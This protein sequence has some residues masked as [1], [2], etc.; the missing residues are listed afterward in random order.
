[1]ANYRIL[2]TVE[3]VGFS[4]LSG[5][6]KKEGKKKKLLHFLCSTMTEHPEIEEHQKGS[7]FTPTL[8][9]CII[10]LSCDRDKELGI[11]KPCLMGL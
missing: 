7:V 8:S 6:I 4:Y 5:K 2:S 3:E 1:M 11:V 9:F 10:W